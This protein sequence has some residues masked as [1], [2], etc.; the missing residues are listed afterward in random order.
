MGITSGSITPEQIRPLE[1]VNFTTPKD[2]PVIKGIDWNKLL[3]TNT[4]Y[5]VNGT[6]NYSNPQSEEPASNLILS[7]LR[8]LCFSEHIII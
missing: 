3:I 7:F 4:T 1:D 8:T 6:I 2:M 5:L